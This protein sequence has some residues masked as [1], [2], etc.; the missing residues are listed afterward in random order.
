MGSFL[1]KLIE[2]TNI[3]KN[4]KRI[5]FKICIDVATMNSILL[6]IST[7]TAAVILTEGKYLLVEVDGPGEDGPEPAGKTM[8]SPGIC[9]TTCCCDSCFP[10]PDHF[11]YP[12]GFRPAVKRGC[13][14]DSQCGSGK[15]C[16]NNQCVTSYPG[17]MPYPYPAK[18]GCTSALEC[19]RRRICKNNKCVTRDHW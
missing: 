15:Q 6:F 19:G 2:N 1:R 9:E 4:Y 7:F 17:Y 5:E 18:P 3:T 14:R 11:I 12:P 16:Q 8:I 10:C 13:T